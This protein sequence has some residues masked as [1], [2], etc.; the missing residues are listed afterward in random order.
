MS[1]PSAPTR[2]LLSTADAANRGGPVGR[3]GAPAAH[4]LFHL[5]SIDLKRVRSRH[6][7]GNYV[8]QQLFEHGT[9]EQRACA[10]QKLVKNVVLVASDCNGGAVLLKAMMNAS[11]AEQQHLAHAMATEPGLVLSI[12]RSRYGHAV[13]QLVFQA[14]GE[15]GK[16]F[17]ARELVA[18][19]EELR[20][21]RPHTHL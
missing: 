5:I 19:A 8:V 16:G 1:D 7:Y 4:L 20:A 3:S 10:V 9:Q 13:V 17:L 11:R 14:L 2:A 18:H 21:S 12:A 15:P 6:P